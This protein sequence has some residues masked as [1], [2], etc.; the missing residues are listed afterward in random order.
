MFMLSD[1]TDRDRVRKNSK[2]GGV[3]ANGV[4]KVGDER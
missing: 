1:I 4:R 3:D 2:E